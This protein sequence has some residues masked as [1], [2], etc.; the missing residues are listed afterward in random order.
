MATGMVT[1]P[2]TFTPNFFSAIKVRTA[3]VHTN[4]SSIS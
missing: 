1:V 4:I 3:R 2:M